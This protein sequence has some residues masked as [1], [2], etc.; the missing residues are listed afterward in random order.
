MRN[1]LLAFLLNLTLLGCSSDKSAENVLNAIKI[2]S[3]SA[4]LTPA[5][6]ANLSKSEFVYLR[7]SFCKAHSL[8]SKY[9]ASSLQK[10]LGREFTNRWAENLPA[11]KT[12]CDVYKIMENLKQ[13]YRLSD[14]WIERQVNSLRKMESFR[15]FYERWRNS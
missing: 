12:Q 4:S 7:E 9:K 15:L 1:L 13:G 10:K 14:D 5:H 6:S 2:L 11:V 8:G 3:E